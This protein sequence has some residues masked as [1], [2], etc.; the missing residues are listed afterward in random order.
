MFRE[1]LLLYIENSQL[2]KFGHLAQ[3]YT[4]GLLVR[5]YGNVKLKAWRLSLEMLEIISQMAW[6]HHGVLLE[7][8][9]KVAA[10]TEVK[11]FFLKLLSS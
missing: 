11:P 7:N 9:E 6:E 3:W 5:I 1:P 2:R 8:L 10:E 4:D